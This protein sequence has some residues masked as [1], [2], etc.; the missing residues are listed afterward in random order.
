MKSV[1]LLRLKYKLLTNVIA[2][3]VCRQLIIKSL[4]LTTN[5]VEALMTGSGVLGR[6]ILD[7]ASLVDCPGGPN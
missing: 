5:T 3:T 4:T 6:A 7:Q 2:V 1:I